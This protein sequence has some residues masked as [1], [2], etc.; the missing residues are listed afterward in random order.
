M[1]KNIIFDIGKV[2]VGFNWQ[3]YIRERY[4]EETA[5]IIR[6]AIWGHGYWHQLDYGVMPEEEI[7]QNFVRFAPEYE[8]QIRDG[9]LNTG[10]CMSRLDYAIPWLKELKAR[11]Y[12]LYFLSNYSRFLIRIRPDVLDFIPYMD[13]GIFSCD[14]H[15]LK[16]DAAIYD[17]LCKKYDLKPEE[18][19]FMD[20]R[21]D[22]IAGA[23]AFGMQG[24]VFETKEQAEKELE[25]ILR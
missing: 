12:N 20:D 7:I 4:D 8:Q 11:G 24:I 21:P 6:K 19:I 9:F 23:I 16:P 22:N 25:A 3:G 17:T 10:D 2:L 14:I 13:G 15:I 1:I 5:A 18:C